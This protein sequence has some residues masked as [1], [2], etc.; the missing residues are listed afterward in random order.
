[1]YKSV[2][3]VV[4]YGVLFDPKTLHNQVVQQNANL[5]KREVWCSG[6]TSY[7]C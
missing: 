3:K 6:E 2:Y 5:F 7:S 4:F 1:M